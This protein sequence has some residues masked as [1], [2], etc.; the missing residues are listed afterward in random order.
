MSRR[1]PRPG[2]PPASAESGPELAPESTL[3]PFGPYEGRSVAWVAVVDA[4]YLRNLVAEAVGSVELRA[5]AARALARR[6]VLEPPRGAPAALERGQGRGAWRG[7]EP[8]DSPPKPPV[9]D[10]TV[11]A[12]DHTVAGSMLLAVL[13]PLARDRRRGAA[14]LILL[15]GLA[16]I[17]WRARVT[18]MVDQSPIPLG[19]QETPALPPGRPVARIDGGVAAPDLLPGDRTTARPDGAGLADGAGRF[20]DLVPATGS[21]TPQPPCGARIPGAIPAESAADFLDSFQAVEFRVVGSKDTGKVTF[22]KPSTCVLGVSTRRE[23]SCRLATC[24]KATQ[25]RRRPPRERG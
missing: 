8:E 14:A 5:S 7:R 12:T 24:S 3:L 25:P 13:A 21:P 2:R 18:R 11:G 19:S 1:K 4:P 16:L 15:V 20:S 6:K 17:A 22:L 23:T 9:A 10:R